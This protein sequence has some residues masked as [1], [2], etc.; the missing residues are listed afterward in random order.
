M[1]PCFRI[2]V[3][4]VC[5]S[6]FVVSSVDA[7]TNDRRWEV[8]FYGGASGASATDGETAVPA[9]GSPITTSS[10]IFPS[11]QVPSWFFGDGARLLNDVNASFALTPRLT[12]LDA[13]FAQPGFDDGTRGTFGVRVRRTVTPRVAAEL[14]L[15][16][17]AAGGG[18]PDA[19][20]DAAESSRATFESA[21]RSLLTSG[22]FSN[23]TVA[24]TEE[25]SGSS[26]R[27]VA[28]TGALNIDLWQRSFVPY[29][30][31]GGG[32]ITPMGDTPAMTLEGRYRFSVLNLLSIDE[33]DRVAVRVDRDSTPVVL[34]GGGVRR[35]VTERWGLRIDGRLLFGPAGYRLIVD[36]TPAVVS[37][38]P[39]GFVESFTAPSVQFSNNSSTGRQS[40]LGGSLRDFTVFESDGIH[41][42]V[43]VT[44][45]VV[46]RF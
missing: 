12:P 7:Q 32:I 33:T 5:L 1:F 29:L 26:R 25:T 16:M 44:A 23:V 10:P 37:A 38:S 4:A 34:A 36:A 43:L 27:D 42:R 46:V 41:A 21:F 14:G 15:Q 3:V 31:V 35:Q 22:P 39:A 9:P 18:L 28:I 30:T 2:V 19:L 40:S 6:V 13:A 45:G 11:R 17:A 20:A 24:A 8:E